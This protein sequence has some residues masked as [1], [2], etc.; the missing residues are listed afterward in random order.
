MT[1]PGEAPEMPWP[2]VE[3]VIVHEE[4][5]ST[6]DLARRLVQNPGL[7]L[8]VAVR[9]VRQTRGRGRGTNTWW[10]DEGSLTT[11]LVLD[12]VA[13]RLKPE[14]E[15]KLAL[16]TALTIVETVEA[17]GRPREP[18]GIRWPN[19][20]EAGGKKLA[21]I[22]PERV[23]TPLPRLLIG[24]G[25]NV[26]TLLDTAPLDVQ[27]LATSVADLL[28][29]INPTPSPEQ[30]FWLLLS[31]LERNLRRLAEDDPSL[32]ERWASLDTLIGR[33][34]RVNL[35]PRVVTGVGRG[36]DADGA[37]VLATENG[38]EQLSGGQVLRDAP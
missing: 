9:A 13:H 6:N 14:H 28:V 15:P 17:Y 11:T 16:V 30:F 37:L 26:K 31:R 5:E 25:V 23:E 20:V 35:G 10:S 7:R 1:T 19:D 8:P 38:V 3:Q 33:A 2:L 32:A 27:K 12:P 4:T 21:G 22:L 24:I 34:V 36:I 18:L 29:T